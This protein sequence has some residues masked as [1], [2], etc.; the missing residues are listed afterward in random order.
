M[1]SSSRHICYPRLQHLVIAGKAIYGTRWTEPMAAAL[2]TTQIDLADWLAGTEVMPPEAAL[3]LNR[4]VRRR[5]PQMAAQC[6]FIERIEARPKF[7]RVALLG[8]ARGRA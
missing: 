6:D 7:Q 2:G 1:P 8:L 3:S 5:A 4:L